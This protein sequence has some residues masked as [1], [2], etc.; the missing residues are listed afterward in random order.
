M[1]ADLS[2]AKIL[3]SL[4][5]QQA[6]N[7]ERAAWHAGQEEL[8]REQRAHYAAEYERVTQHLEA[9]QAT[10]GAAAEIAARALPATP[11]PEKEEDEIPAG[12]PP[13]RSRLLERMVREL[14]TGTVFGPAW[15]AQE[16]NQRFPRLLPKPVTFRLASNALC[17]MAAEGLLQVARKGTSH[18]EARYR[19][20]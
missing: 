4:E 14:Q 10:A 18:R 12:K 1:D 19:K 6:F 13:M 16:A 20:L 3:A 5:A 9:F 11:E 2:V 7:K 8:H 15:L 17:K